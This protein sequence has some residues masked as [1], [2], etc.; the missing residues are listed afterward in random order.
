MARGVGP[1]NRMR[2]LII[3]FPIKKKKNLVY[4]INKLS[5]LIKNLLVK[6][7]CCQI[8]WLGLSMQQWARLTWESKPQ[9]SWNFQLR[10]HV[11]VITMS[12]PK[13]RPHVLHRTTAC[14][15][16][17]AAENENDYPNPPISNVWLRNIFLIVIVFLWYNLFYK[18]NK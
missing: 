15:F 3:V 7:V 12:W 10:R 6:R 16:T 13:H 11:A 17:S 2:G 9:Y 14:Y 1:Y 4:F 8:I 18:Y 5:Y